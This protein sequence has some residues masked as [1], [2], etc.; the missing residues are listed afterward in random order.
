MYIT[1]TNFVATFEPIDTIKKEYYNNFDNS[2]SFN[3]PTVL[4]IPDNAPDELPRI[5]CQSKNG[6]SQMTLTKNSISLSTKFDGNFLQN[7]NLCRTYLKCKID[8]IIN[9][10]A[11]ISNGNLTLKNIGLVTQIL[12]DQQTSDTTKELVDR[13]AKIRSTDNAYDFSQKLTYV[14][15]SK[16]FINLNINNVRLIDGLSTEKAGFAKKYIDNKIGVI[17]DVNDRYAFNINEDYHS[18]FEEITTI[19]KFTDDYL[20]NIEKFVYNAEVILWI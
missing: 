16:Y 17:I 13:F 9:P 5:I 10:F 15:E 7:W 19:T 18:S 12:L 20:K 14:K 3:E 2:N 8:E 1:D 6:H 11:K 4:P